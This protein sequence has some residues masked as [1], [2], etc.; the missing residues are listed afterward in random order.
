MELIILLKII[1]IKN[2]KLIKTTNILEVPINMSKLREKIY[3][4]DKKKFW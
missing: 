1:Q 2:T 3:I 4:P